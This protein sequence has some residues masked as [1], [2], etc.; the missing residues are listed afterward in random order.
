MIFDIVIFVACSYVLFI[1]GLFA[2]TYC[3]ALQDQGAMFSLAVL[4]PLYLFLGVYFVADF[5]FNATAGTVIFREVPREWGFTQRVKRQQANE[6]DPVRQKKAAL[7]ARRLNK[8]NPR[9]V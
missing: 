7:W 6:S 8:I 9:H 3:K 5:V 4:V 1:G 2:L